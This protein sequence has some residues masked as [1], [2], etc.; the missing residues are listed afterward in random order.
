MPVGASAPA[1]SPRHCLGPSWARDPRGRLPSVA[2]AGG[3]GPLVLEPPGPTW[4]SQPPSHVWGHMNLT[5]EGPDSKGPDPR[6][7]HGS[8]T[9][10]AG[11]LRALVREPILRSPPARTSEVEKTWHSVL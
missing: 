2:P 11:S 10:Y 9:N 1:P 3:T 5:R 8:G 6:L 7:K 4:G